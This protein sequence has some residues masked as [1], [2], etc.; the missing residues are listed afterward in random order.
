MNEIK[1]QVPDGFD[2]IDEEKSDL[3]N[4]II[5]FKEKKHTPWRYT[6]PK[7]DGW[8]VGT[9]SGIRHTQDSVWDTDNM[10]KFATEKQARAMLAMAQLSQIIQNDERFG[11]VVTDE[12]WGNECKTKYTISRSRNVIKCFAITYDYSFLAFHTKEQRDLFLQENEDLIRQYLML[13]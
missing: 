10:N 12:E 8:Y 13:D 7:L 2:G 1:I 4:G 6:K 5:I 3:S 11:G 9:F